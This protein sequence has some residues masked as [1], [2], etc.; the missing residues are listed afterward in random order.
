MM[1]RVKI[2]FFVFGSLFLSALP[3]SNAQ[4][5][6]LDK[7]IQGEWIVVSRVIAGKADKQFLGGT[8][9]LSEAERTEIKLVSGQSMNIKFIRRVHDEKTKTFR[10]SIETSEDDEGM[11]G[12]GPRKG[13]CKLNEK[14][15]LEIVET[16]SASHDFPNDF[17]DAT[18]AAAMYWKLTK[19]PEPKK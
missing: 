2:V 4:E 8:L 11:G 10:F 14:G 18:K 3:A 15:E 6:D 12:G 13:I 9:L 17:S 1:F 19:K 5:K 7:L 16:R